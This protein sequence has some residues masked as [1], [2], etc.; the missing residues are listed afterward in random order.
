[1]E[2]YGSLIYHWCRASNL[3]PEDAKDVSQEVLQT[4]AGKIKEFRHDRTGD[5]FRGWL[6]TITRYK[7]GD[8]IR[9]H[10]AQPQAAGG[11]EAHAKLQEIAES[12]FPSTMGCKKVSEED[13]LS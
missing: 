4:V 12:D 9:R 11:T 7:I 8:H 5:T 3:R 13:L 6:R 10:N 1:V 2:L